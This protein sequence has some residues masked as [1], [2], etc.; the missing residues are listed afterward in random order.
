[1]P[2]GNDSRGR[3]VAWHDHGP[4]MLDLMSPLRP[5]IGPEA[6][7]IRPECGRESANGG[8]GGQDCEPIMS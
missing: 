7:P 4:A 2:G 6:A 8:H 1:M 5:V 3:R